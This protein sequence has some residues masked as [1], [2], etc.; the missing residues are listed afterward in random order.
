MTETAVHPYAGHAPVFTVDSRV[1]GALA[2]DLLRL[3]VEEGTLGLRTLVARFVAVGPTSDGS[4]SDLL[5]LDG[6][7]VDI[8]R[9]V[10]VALGPPGGERTV[11]RGTI[12]AIE[13][14][15]AEGETPH[16]A[17][18]AEDALMRLRMRERTATYVDVT[19]ANV[20]DRIASEHGLGSAGD[21][22]G[23]THPV[24][25]QWEQS[26]LAFLRDRA[27]R[28]DAEL[29]VDSD[30]VIHMA[31]RE[32]RDGA[33][34]QLVQGNELIEARARVDVAHQRTEVEVRG[35]D[36]VAVA[37]V[38]ETAGADL[39]AAEI[40]SGRSGPSVIAEVFPDASLVR[41][42]RDV[43][44]SALARRYAEAELR[45]RARGF[46]TVDGVTAGTPDLV[47]G[48]RLDLRRM[49]PPFE[50]DGYRVCHAH[51]SYDLVHG[52]RTRFR[53]E[54]AAVRR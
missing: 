24:L 39:I 31:D 16:V 51:H 50:G 25:Q 42:R 13:V 33:E 27:V 3:D 32:Q 1:E 40:T 15:F 45:R 28:L 2:R 49:G 26:D 53:A 17:L 5:Y 30:D 36:D 6:E 8:G 46:V 18:H 38:S 9:Q 10:E 52:H 21:V 43:R 23:P 12:T 34:I 4:A 11:F 54:R 14:A 41:S 29:W 19:D 35:W 7:V 48:A 47:P 22:D 20:L 44:T 37:A